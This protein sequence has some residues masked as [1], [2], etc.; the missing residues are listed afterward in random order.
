M[1]KSKS[2]SPSSRT[3]PISR[4][5]TP[6]SARGVPG[7]GIHTGGNNG[8]GMNNGGGVVRQPRGPADGGGFAGNGNSNGNSN[9]MG[10]FP[11]GW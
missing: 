1:E 5:R 4:G 6:D 3:P 7:G 9:G 11:P 2:N 8:G 10:T